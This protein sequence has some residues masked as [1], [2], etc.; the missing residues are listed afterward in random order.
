MTYAAVHLNLPDPVLATAR[1]LARC[2]G[3]TLAT[4]IENALLCEI[5]RSDFDVVRDD[6]IQGFAASESW[7][8]VQG[9]LALL[10]FCL[11]DGHGDL[12]L[13]RKSDGAYLCDLGELGQN[14]KEL[15]LRYGHP[16]PGMAQRWQI[17]QSAD[18]A[19]GM[20]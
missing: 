4:F 1:R 19:C 17:D 16:F 13:H 12:S 5:D 2:R 9:R 11:R 7:Q 14:A 3:E 10:G 20:R 8:E 18:L 6:L 15:T